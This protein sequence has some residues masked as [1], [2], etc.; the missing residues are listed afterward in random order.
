MLPV[1]NGD[2]L[3]QGGD[4]GGTCPEADEQRDG[5]DVAPGGGQDG[6]DRV[7]NQI[8]GDLGVEYPVQEPADS[9]VHV[10]QCVLSEQRRDQSVRPSRASSIGAV[11][12]AHQNA[13]WELSPNKELPQALDRVRAATR[14]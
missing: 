3:D 9:D 2:G 6:V 14:R 1:G 13:A 4:G 5:Y 8:V 10:G 7:T 12:R 11:D